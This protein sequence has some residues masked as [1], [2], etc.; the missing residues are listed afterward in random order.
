MSSG[1][2]RSAIAGRPLRRIHRRHARRLSSS[3]CTPFLKG[4]CYH[5][6]ESLDTDNLSTLLGS[7]YRI[8]TMSLGAENVSTRCVYRRTPACLSCRRIYLLPPKRSC[9][10]PL[11]A[12]VP[13][14]PPLCMWI[15]PCSEEAVKTDSV[16]DCALVDAVHTCVFS[17]DRSVSPG[18]AL[19]PEQASSR[20]SPCG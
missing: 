8:Q 18:H 10:D 3:P 11:C 16:G 2:S 13:G 4:S 7:R 12:D 17:V 14:W 9:E 1:S 15:A 20:R 6:H 5:V 19:D